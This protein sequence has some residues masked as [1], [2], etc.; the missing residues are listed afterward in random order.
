MSDV[1]EHVDVSR[2]LH[3]FW[4]RRHLVATFCLSASLTSLILT[5]V[6][7]EKYH[8]YTT[9]LYRPQEA[10]SFRPKVQ[11][12]LGFPPPLVPLETIGN[13]IEQVAKS[14]ATLAEIVRRL[15]L[16]DKRPRADEGWLKRT[17]RTVKDEAKGRVGE[18]WQI[19]KYGRVIPKDPFIGAMVDLAKNLSVKRGTKT[20]TFRLEVLNNSPELSALIVDTAAEVLANSLREENGR[21]AAQERERIAQRLQESEQETE[22][23]RAELEQFKG[24]AQVASLDEER[25][26]RLT[27]ISTFDDELSRVENELRSL[28]GRHQAL[29]SQLA[30]QPETLDYSS[31]QS[32]NPVVA[33]LR[34]AE[35]EKQVARS[36]LL[37]T[38]TENHPLV[39]E[40]D[41]GLAQIRDQLNNVPQRVVS[42][43]SSRLND[44][45][46]K[47]LS[48]K[49]TTE[50]EL[51]ALQ[52]KQQA[53]VAALES[54]RVKLAE[55]SSKEPR[56]KELMLR[57]ETAEHSYGLISEA[58]EEARIAETK[59]ASELAI[60]HPA[61]VPAAPSRPIKVL[62]VGAAA[63]LSLLLA[64][65]AV[66]LFDFF[67]TSIRTLD[68]VE[69][70]L[71]I[72]V[73]TTIPPMEPTSSALEGV[74]GSS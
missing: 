40:L 31:T 14:D 48:D 50:T 24:S 64:F 33:Q 23:L 11:E 53:L 52:A 1:Q 51:Q 26:L 59:A 6:F 68:Q 65:G 63:A 47:L 39:L 43:E 44:L 10:T 73:L 67:D 28:E 34:L 2:Y 20:Y 42:E 60:L 57:L 37:E 38:Y 29:S 46:Q 7:S 16:D 17:F 58:H 8:A 70:L 72:S 5:Y 55:L 41:A 4:K 21:V 15:K 45:H 56:F 9:V 69:G 3:L 19:L 22:A 54:E 49:L 74:D 13:T 36:A 18:L 66:F 61:M 12:A 27:S 30:N 32:Q 25:S 62:H 35:A 71:G